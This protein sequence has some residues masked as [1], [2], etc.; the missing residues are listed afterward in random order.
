[1]ATE[2]ATATTPLTSEQ[3]IRF[4]EQHCY[5]PLANHPMLSSRSREF[6]CVSEYAARYGVQISEIEFDNAIAN[7]FGDG[8]EWEWAS[9]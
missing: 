9:E 5:T 2:T 3:R 8:T 1:M 6:T 7:R 4:V